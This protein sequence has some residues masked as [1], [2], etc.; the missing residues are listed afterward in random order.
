MI[1]A[2]K[3]EVPKLFPYSKTNHS[4]YI[5]QK[6]GVFGIHDYEGIKRLFQLRERLSP[7]KNH[8]KLHNFVDTPYLKPLT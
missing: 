3:F 2:P 5:V 7:L 4:K 8:K 6:K 1:L